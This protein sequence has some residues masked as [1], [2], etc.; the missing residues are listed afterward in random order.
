MFRQTAVSIAIWVLRSC[1]LSSNNFY[2]ILLN[3]LKIDYFSSYTSNFCCVNPKLR[4]C[5]NYQGSWHLLGSWRRKQAWT[6]RPSLWLLSGLLLYSAPSTQR[7]WLQT[8]EE[9]LDFHDFKVIKLV[10]YGKF[11]EQCS[12]P[13]DE[14]A[15]S[16]YLHLQDIAFFSHEHLSL[17]NKTPCTQCNSTKA[18]P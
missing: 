17:N 13:C 6:C 16:M 11:K 10:I 7:P 14:P 5:F 9:A 12:D 2:C 8:N 15:I 4:S 3:T 18:H 1:L